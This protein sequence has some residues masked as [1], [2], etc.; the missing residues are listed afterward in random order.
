MGGQD[1]IED[2]FLFQLPPLGTCNEKVSFNLI[3]KCMKTQIYKIKGV[4][5]KDY[6]RF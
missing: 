3:H 1:L 5:L 6:T 4:Y 2:F